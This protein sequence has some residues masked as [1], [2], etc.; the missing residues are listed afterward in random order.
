VEISIDNLLHNINQI[1]SILNKQQD[2][3]AVVKDNSYG[4]GALPIAKALTTHGAIKHFAVARAEEAFAL[5]NNGINEQIIVLGKCSIDQI[6]EGYRKKLTFTLNDLSDFELWNQS[7]IPVTFHCNIDTAMHR[8][9]ILPEEIIQLVTILKKYPQFN[10]E[11]VFTHLAQSDV[12]GTNTV[13]QQRTMLLNCVDQLKRHG[14]APKHVHYGNSAGLMRFPMSESTLVRPG[15]SI[16]GC[17]PDPAQEFILSLEPIASLKGVVAKIKEVPAQTPVSYGANYITKKKTCI[18]TIPIG[19]AHGLPR[20]L[21]SKGVVLIHGKRYRIAGNVTMDY[22]MVDIGLNSKIAIGD[23]VVA[24][25]RQKNEFISPDEI[26]L[27][28]RT[29]GY[30]VL[31][32]L[33]RSLEHRYYYNGNLVLQKD[34]SFF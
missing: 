14:I 23:E 28:G 19:Y 22:T 26:A 29:I 17:K 1:R 5:R 30:E 34:A 9:G 8:M 4:C 2:I 24:I 20:F 15:I 21:S 25:G 12:P 32:N 6:T 11:G 16:Y 18:A 7:T 13:D 27:V 3:I 10:L 33:G 31:C